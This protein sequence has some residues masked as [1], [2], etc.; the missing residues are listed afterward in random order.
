MANLYSSA[1]TGN[2]Y[3]RRAYLRSLKELATGP[4][5]AAN[6]NP[7]MQAK[8]NAMVA[9][10]VTPISPTVSVTGW[11]ASAR[12]SILSQVAGLDSPSFILATNSITTN[13]N[14]I[15]ISGT[16]PLELETIRI[17]GV[18]YP[19]IWTSSTNFIL[20][21]PLDT[22][23]ATLVLQG[24][25]WRG[26]PLANVSNVVTASYTGPFDLAQDSVVFSEIMFQ[27]SATNASYVEFQNKSTNFAFDVSGWRVNGLGFS[28][29]PGTIIPSGQ[30]MLVVKD[31][32]AFYSAFPNISAPIAVF[33]GNL[34]V[35]G[36]TLTLIKS[37][38]TPAEDIVVDRV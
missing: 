8:Y 12:S 5:A 18:E 32:G 7:I 36:E 29:A 3:V 26:N 4:M 35:D 14:L 20:R 17:N 22:P 13:N 16:A 6:I 19:L 1:S 27:P 11:I 31:R 10:G 9:S 34:D 25:D 30:R 37:G 24:Y 15:A 38:A 28:F 2:L 23:T 33:D 21:T